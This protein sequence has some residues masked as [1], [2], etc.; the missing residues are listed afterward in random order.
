MTK[1]PKI[2][3]KKLVKL[4][5]SFLINQKKKTMIILVTLLLKMVVVVEVV[6]EVLVVLVVPISPTFLRIF[7]AISAVAEEE[8]LE[9]ET[10]IIEA[11]I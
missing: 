10:Q 1:S 6:L 5:V 9:E 2:N 8:V 4:T 7:L 3:L 11:Q